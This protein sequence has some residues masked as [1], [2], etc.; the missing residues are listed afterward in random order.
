MFMSYDSGS[1]FCHMA[2]N[3]NDCLF[4]L[5][6]YQFHDIV[7][8]MAFEQWNQVNSNLCSNSIIYLRQCE[9]IICHSLNIALL[10]CLD[11]PDIIYIK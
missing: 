4:I 11:L 7:L 2:S 9:L 3:K 10:I 6:F 1:H 5:V 8:Y